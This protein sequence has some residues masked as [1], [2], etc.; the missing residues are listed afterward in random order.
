MCYNPRNHYMYRTCLILG[1]LL[2]CKL[3]Q[4]QSSYN[5]LNIYAIYKKTY[6]VVFH[7]ERDIKKLTS[8]DTKYTITNAQKMMSFEG[9]I[10]QMP[11]DL[12]QKERMPFKA[13]G[14][15]I[16]LEFIGN[17]GDTLTCGIWRSYSVFVNG[18]ETKLNGK[19]LIEQYLKDYI[20]PMFG[21]YREPI[22]GKKR[23]KPGEEDGYE[24]VYPW[25]AQKQLEKQ[26]LDYFVGSVSP[27]ATELLNSAILLTI[28]VQ[29]KRIVSVKFPINLDTKRGEMSEAVY[30][31]YLR[32]LS[33]RLPIINIKNPYKLKADV[34]Y[35]LL[36]F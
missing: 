4:A 1:L 25:N 10:K 15:Y 12:K 33:Y 17:K 21:W 6:F 19:K 29:R 35:R 24:I 30:K 11:T 13:G 3:S 5:Q 26:N 27:L 18:Y 28:D 14:G 22:K 9:L 7:Y 2:L 34:I 23:S 31:K 8:T 16:L 20:S 36:S 32:V